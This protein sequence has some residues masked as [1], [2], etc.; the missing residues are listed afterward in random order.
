MLA[1]SSGN[2]GKF[3]LLTEEEVL[4]EKG[5]LEKAAT[6]KISEQLP[7]DCEL[8]KN[9]A[10]AKNNIKDQKKC[11]NLMEQQIKIIKSNT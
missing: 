3:E 9:S 8:K 10:I 7:L 4:L 6:I 2:V 5:I 11:M 1:L